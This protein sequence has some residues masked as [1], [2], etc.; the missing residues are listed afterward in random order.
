MH[1]SE[2][3]G[4]LKKVDGTQNSQPQEYQGAFWRKTRS[5][6]LKNILDGTQS[7]IYGVGGGI[8]VGQSLRSYFPS[9]N[10]WRPAVFKASAQAHCRTKCGGE[11]HLK[12]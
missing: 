5:W 3:S 4:P 6:A 2:C 1:V 12:V 11:G 10:H 9:S 8:L 7:L